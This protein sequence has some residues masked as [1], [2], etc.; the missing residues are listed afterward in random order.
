M[1][2]NGIGV[3]MRTFRAICNRAINLDFVGYEWYPFRK[4]KIQKSKTTPRVLSMEEIKSYFQ[5][6]LQAEDPEYKY[7]NL[8]KLIFALPHKYIVLSTIFFL[9]PQ[10]YPTDTINIFDVITFNS[11]K[12][13]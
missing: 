5:L 13:A 1:S 8:G 7:W 3:Y 12:M 2:I 11:L 6:D 9:L 4:Y 10:Y